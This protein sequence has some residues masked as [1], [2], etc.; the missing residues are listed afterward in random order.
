M[1][2]TTKDIWAENGPR[3]LTIHLTVKIFQFANSSLPRGK[4]LWE[5]IIAIE[6]PLFIAIEN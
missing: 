1:K 3:K 6:N 4:F 5:T 2:T